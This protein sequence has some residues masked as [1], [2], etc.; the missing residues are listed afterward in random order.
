MSGAAVP[1]DI[2][3]G[4]FEDESRREWVKVLGRDIGGLDAGPGG[5]P[6]EAD[7]LGVG[8]EGLDW[9]EP[10]GREDRQVL[11][12]QGQR[13][14]EGVDPITERGRCVLVCPLV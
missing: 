4:A 7:V 13:D 2:P 12:H 11:D 8:E 9:I 1:F 3:W 6:D 14:L 10:S 5:G